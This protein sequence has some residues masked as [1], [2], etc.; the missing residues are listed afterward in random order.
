MLVYLLRVQSDKDLKS[1]M[2]SLLI[3]IT[4]LRGLFFEGLRKSA[5]EKVFLFLA[6]SLALS[7][8]PSLSAPTFSIPHDLLA[9]RAFL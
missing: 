8:P 2:E 9:A 6:R 5:E 1:R 4:L 3:D 7:I